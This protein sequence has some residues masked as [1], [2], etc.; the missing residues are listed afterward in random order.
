MGDIIMLQFFRSECPFPQQ[1]FGQPNIMLLRVGLLPKKA[2][3]AEEEP[4]LV[5]DDRTAE[6]QRGVF[7]I[8]VRLGRADPNRNPLFVGQ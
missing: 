2:A 6:T 1:D 3:A 8:L 4:E 7:V 5:F